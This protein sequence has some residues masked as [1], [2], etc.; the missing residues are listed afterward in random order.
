[1]PSMMRGIWMGEA[2]EFGSA[3]NCAMANCGGFQT[4]VVASTDQS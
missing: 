4:E 3:M 2:D 1:V